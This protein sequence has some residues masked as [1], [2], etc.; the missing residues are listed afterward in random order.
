MEEEG[1]DVGL[2]T[3]HFALKEQVNNFQGHHFIK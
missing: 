2:T 3:F 1:T